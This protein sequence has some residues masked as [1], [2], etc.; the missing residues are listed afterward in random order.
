MPELYDPAI[1]K[2]SKLPEGNFDGVI[3]FV[4]SDSLQLNEKIFLK[5][6]DFLSK[7]VVME[8]KVVFKESF[9]PRVGI[10]IDNFL[11]FCDFFIIF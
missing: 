9:L 4:V 3:S 1:E 2:F 6:F 10:I 8:D 7:E 11:A 5:Q